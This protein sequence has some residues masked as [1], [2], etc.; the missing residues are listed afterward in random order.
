MSTMNSDSQQQTDL[1]DL[2]ADM[3]GNANTWGEQSTLHKGE[4]GMYCIGRMESYREAELRIRHIIE[5]HY[6]DPNE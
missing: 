6:G 5:K 3:R 1:L 4:R 2:L